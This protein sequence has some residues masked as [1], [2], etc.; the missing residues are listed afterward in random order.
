MM[1]SPIRI[2]FVIPSTNTPAAPIN[3]TCQ[4]LSHEF[5]SSLPY[6]DGKAV[7]RPDDPFKK[8]VTNIALGV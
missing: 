4:N 2:K 5:T 8:T 3:T 7:D 1:E 6:F